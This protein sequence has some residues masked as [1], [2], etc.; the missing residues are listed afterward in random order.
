MLE[1]QGCITTETPRRVKNIQFQ[2]LNAVFPL[3]IFCLTAPSSGKRVLCWLNRAPC[4]AP[5]AAEQQQDKGRASQGEFRQSGIR[6]PLL[7]YFLQLSLEE[8]GDSCMTKCRSAP[9]PSYGYPQE[10]G[11]SSQHWHWRSSAKTEGNYSETFPNCCLTA[12]LKKASAASTE[13]ASRHMNAID[14]FKHPLLRPFKK[15]F[16]AECQSC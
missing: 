2:C 3:A 16:L 12:R 4:S 14:G 8:I 5:T 11:S 6:Q 1:V 7:S 13:K 10:D 9:A 15:P